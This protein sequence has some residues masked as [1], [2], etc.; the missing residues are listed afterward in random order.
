MSTLI[1]ASLKYGL[2][3]GICLY[4]VWQLSSGIAA[5][6][7]STRDMLQLHMEATIRLQQTLDRQEHWQAVL[8]DL[9][10]QQCV[11]SAKSA[12][13]RSGC[14]LGGGGR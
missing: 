7:R 10:R 1:S 6:V 12:S 3:P 4:L 8:V 5:D 13:E 14:F 2:A 9:S 11:N